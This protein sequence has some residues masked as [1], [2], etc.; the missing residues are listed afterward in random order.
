MFCSFCLSYF[1]KSQQQ[2]NNWN[3][4]DGIRMPILHNL[5]NREPQI[6]WTFQL[7]DWE[8]Q[9]ASW[10]LGASWMWPNISLG[11]QSPVEGSWAG[12]ICFSLDNMRQTIIPPPPSCSFEGH[13]PS[14]GRQALPSGLAC[15]TVHDWQPDTSLRLDII[16]LSVTRKGH[17]K[18]VTRKILITN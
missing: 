7:L 12:I 14:R 9:T 18:A 10:S 2:I 17:Q 11:A 13:N 6:T 1:S 8:N 4:D 16:H 3:W 15:L 5:W